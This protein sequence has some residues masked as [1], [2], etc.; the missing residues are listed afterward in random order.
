MPASRAEYAIAL[1]DS[2]SAEQLGTRRS[3]TQERWMN[4]GGGALGGHRRAAVR[5]ALSAALSVAL[6]GVVLF[7]VREAWTWRQAPAGRWPSNPPAPARQVPANPV[8]VESAPLPS[9]AGGVPTEH[10]VAATGRPLTT[11]APRSK[12]AYADAIQA[13]RARAQQYMRVWFSE[14]VMQNRQ[15]GG[16][17][18][19]DDETI[20]RAAGRISSGEALTVDSYDDFCRNG[21]VRVTVR[22]RIGDVKDVPGPPGPGK[23]RD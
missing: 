8:A 12:E 20:A 3:T 2:T 7:S 21:F 4:A 1:H 18:R 9:L 19:T 22:F 10:V 6:L 13:A 15:A 16:V 5:R 11:L 23:G 17:G 14:L